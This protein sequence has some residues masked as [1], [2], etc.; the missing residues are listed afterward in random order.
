MCCCFFLLIVGERG[1]NT[2]IDHQYLAMIETTR[3]E[4]ARRHGTPATT[5]K[6]P[7]RREN[8]ARRADSCRPSRRD[9]STPEFCSSFR[10]FYK[11]WMSKIWLLSWK[12]DQ[13]GQ[14]T[15]YTNFALAGCSTAATIRDKSPKS[16]NAPRCIHVE[17]KLAYGYHNLMLPFLPRRLT[18]TSPRPCPPSSH[19]PSY[20]E[21]PCPFHP[22]FASLASG[23][24][25]YRQAGR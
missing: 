15:S 23:H 2:D 22:G 17:H 16:R 12:T 21:Q 5:T 25:L 4:L 11:M 13:N 1:P 7:L 9:Y 10:G 6:R 20:P 19:P 18:T 8:T 14:E 24:A 3:F